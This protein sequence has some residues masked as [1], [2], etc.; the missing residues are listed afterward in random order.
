V[1][2]KLANAGIS[3]IFQAGLRSA[4]SALLVWAWS[5]HR[6]VRLFASDARSA[7][8]SSSAVLFGDGVAFLAAILWGA[9]TGGDQSITARPV[10]AEVGERR[11]AP[12]KTRPTRP[13]S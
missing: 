3:P 1:A 11:G 12:L 4:G 8:A 10:G 7:S 6:G 2:I 13:F 9:T 5:A